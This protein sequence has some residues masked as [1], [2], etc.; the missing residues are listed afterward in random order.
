MERGNNEF[1]IWAC[2]I[3]SGKIVKN[4]QNNMPSFGC[5]QPSTM[6][7]SQLPC[8]VDVMFTWQM[9]ELTF[10]EAV[11][12]KTTQLLSGR[13]SPFLPWCKAQVLCLFLK[14]TAFCEVCGLLSYYSPFE[15]AS[16][17]VSCIHKDC[18]LPSS[19]SAPSLSNGPDEQVLP[20]PH[21][22]Y[23]LKP[24]NKHVLC[25]CKGFRQICWWWE[26]SL[27]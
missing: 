12:P 27:C 2:W 8:K 5:H 10:R 6:T 26:M 1:F 7:G 23:F 11:S 3:N 14:R 24:G 20:S 9:S 19:G 18:D 13:T 21:L 17:Y 16:E 4:K 25:P 22:W 15:G